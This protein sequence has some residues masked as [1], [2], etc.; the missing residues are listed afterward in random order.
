LVVYNNGQRDL[1]FNIK[2]NGSIAPVTLH[3]K[4]VGTYVWN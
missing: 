1:T 4:S 3:K 2:Y